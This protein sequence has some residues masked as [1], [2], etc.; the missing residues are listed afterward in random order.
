MR[1]SN[2]VLI[3]MPGS[4]KSTI[5]VLLAKRAAMAFVDT[6]LLIQTQQGRTLQAIVDAEGP[7]ALRRIEERVLLGLELRRQ[8][9]ATGG[10]AV[11]SPAAMGHLARDGRIVFLDVPLPE[12]QRR[13]VDL[14]SRGIARLPGQSLADLFR[15]RRPLYRRHAQV[16]IACGGLSQEALCAA[17]LEALAAPA[18]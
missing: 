9:I 13:I 3:G 17:I 1:P 18:A 12:L 16:T 7:A 8:V 10:S 14:A 2:L 5:G 15:E 4:G 11:Y 6:D